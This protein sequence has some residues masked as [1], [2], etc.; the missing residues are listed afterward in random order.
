M[1]RLAAK[2]WYRNSYFEARPVCRLPSRERHCLRHALNT[3]GMTPNQSRGPPQ[4]DM[5]GGS[6]EGTAV[7][8]HKIAKRYNFGIS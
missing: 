3:R 4:Q 8:N 7:D 2:I 1:I 5:N 6:R